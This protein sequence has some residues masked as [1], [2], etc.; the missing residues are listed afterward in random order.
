MKVDRATLLRFVLFFQLSKNQSE[1][2]EAEETQ[3]VDC[4]AA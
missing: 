1:E 2:N 4:H 3:E